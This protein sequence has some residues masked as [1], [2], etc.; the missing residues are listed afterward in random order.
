M[1]SI[2][3][4]LSSRMSTFGGGGFT[5]VCWARARPGTPSSATPAV[6]AI[7]DRMNGILMISLLRLPH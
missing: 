4:E 2:E 3:P 7:K 5:S 6:A 1:R